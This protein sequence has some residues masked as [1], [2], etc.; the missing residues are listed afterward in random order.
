MSCQLYTYVVTCKDKLSYDRDNARCGTDEPWNNHPG[1]LKVI[2]C[3]AN[4]RGIYNFIL[5]LNSNLTSIF[6]RS[7]DNTPSLDIHEHY[8]KIGNNATIRSNECI[9][10]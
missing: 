6:N 1:S 3:C 8:G 9:A 5:A 10:R 4:R 7:W 2:R